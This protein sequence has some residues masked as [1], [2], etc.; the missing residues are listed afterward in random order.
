[1]EHM[2]SKGEASTNNAGVSWSN[3]S[4]K[5]NKRPNN[6]PAIKHNYKS[7][8]KM[9]STQ[10][11]N[12]NNQS[13][14]FKKATQPIYSYENNVLKVNFDT[15]SLKYVIQTLFN[16]QA[17]LTD[18]FRIWNDVINDVIV[19][20]KLIVEKIK[21][22]NNDSVFNFIKRDK[23]VIDNPQ[24]YFEYEDDKIVKKY[25]RTMKYREVIDINSK[26]YDLLFNYV[27][28]HSWDANFWLSVLPRFNI[29]LNELND[30]L[31]MET[32]NN[33]VAIY[34]ELIRCNI[35]EFPKDTKRTDELWVLV[36]K[37]CER[38]E[39]SMEYNNQTST[40]I[41]KD[42]DMLIKLFVTEISFYKN[43]EDV[44]IQLPISFEVGT[45]N[46]NR[47]TL[48]DQQKALST[49]F[50]LFEQDRYK[51]E[52]L[53]KICCHNFIN[54]TNQNELVIRR[55]SAFCNEDSL[56]DLVNKLCFFISTKSGIKSNEHLDKNIQTTMEKYNILF[57]VLDAH[58]KTISKTEDSIHVNQCYLI[59]GYQEIIK[60]SPTYIDEEIKVIVNKQIE[61]RLALSL[62]ILSELY[63]GDRI[64]V[65]PIVSNT[66]FNSVEQVVN[67]M[68]KRLNEYKDY[69]IMCDELKPLLLWYID[70]DYYEIH[71]SHSYVSLSILKSLINSDDEDAKN[72]LK[73]WFKRHK[74]KLHNKVIKLFE[75]SE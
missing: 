12:M 28:K 58:L 14:T 40:I 19:V 21:T 5:Y 71:N 7:K 54:D 20:K 47:E 39:R 46:I 43:V 3:P 24:N 69:I 11:T 16:Q 44:R 51:H 45:I 70:K 22:N 37:F 68:I 75:N 15:V 59:D 38:L 8:D 27:V 53:I 74:P 4:I 42:F 29:P 34:T 41:I 25:K 26:Q 10:Q 23:T 56:V 30:C 64:R 60:E 48:I 67:K 50:S 61:P 33:L 35:A 55:K 13:Q 57:N 36:D 62:N 65:L 6:K 17:S 63:Y 72:E 2:S 32:V 52:T 73:S 9:T 49:L 18:K 66:T 31:T 1:M